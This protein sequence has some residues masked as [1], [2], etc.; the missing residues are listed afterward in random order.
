MNFIF[1]DVLFENTP[2]FYLLR[3][4]G[5]IEHVN[6]NF[7]YQLDEIKFTMKWIGREFSSKFHTV[8]V[9]FFSIEKLL[10]CKR[11]KTPRR[12]DEI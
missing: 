2:Q 9:Q 10:D 3:L 1:F 6:K 12:A 11:D 8:S 5:N 7:P 4:Y